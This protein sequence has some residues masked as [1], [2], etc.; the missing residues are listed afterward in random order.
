MSEILRQ[1]VTLLIGSIP[2][3]VI[4]LI[5]LVAYHQLVHG[6]LLRT[7]AERRART[8]GAVE[9]AQAAIAA[10]E[11]R[12]AEYDAKLR[13]AR[14][15]LMRAREELLHQWQTERE[16]AIEQ[17]RATTRGQVDAALRDIEKSTIAAR[18]KIESMS[19]ELA[20]QVVDA[21]LPTAGGAR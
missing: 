20:T 8:S 11:K 5:L 1:L 2:T 14:V 16:A 7:L 6:P 19:G 17:V 18:K 4:F 3:M 10:A 21:V 15:A 13:E 9:K 12:T